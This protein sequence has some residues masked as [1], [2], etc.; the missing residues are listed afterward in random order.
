M[1]SWGSVVFGVFLIVFGTI[2]LLDN[3]GYLDS[4]YVFENFWPLILV[5]VGIAILLRPK[6]T[7][8]LSS[9]HRLSENRNQPG[10]QNFPESAADYLV[11]SAVF[12]DI[13]ATV[14]SKNFSGGSC[15]VVFGR[16]QVDLTAAEFKEGQS[17]LRLNSV[18][19]SVVVRVSPGHEVAINATLFA[20][21]IHAKDQ[22]RAGLFET[23][24]F[25]S[26][27]FE[28]ADKKLI[29][30]ISQMFGDVKVF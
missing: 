30:Q 26:P 17:T 4:E 14:T 27:D 18:F 29:I 2:F 6:R 1:R 8:K 9:E 22:R 15:S 24:V 16:I 19:G 28:T 12:G 21:E 3:F 13:E 11:R 25:K 10:Y 7:A 5:I 20:G 23:L